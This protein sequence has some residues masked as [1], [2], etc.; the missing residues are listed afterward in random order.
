MGMVSGFFIFSI[1][2]SAF[3]GLFKGGQFFWEPAEPERSER[4]FETEP[5]EPEPVISETEP[6]RTEPELSWKLA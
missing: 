4:D 6:N 3:L 2:D 1:L 5:L